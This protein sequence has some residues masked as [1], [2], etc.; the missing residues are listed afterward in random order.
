M[1]PLKKKS[2]LPFDLVSTVAFHMSCIVHSLP[3]F[4]KRRI[5]KKTTDKPVQE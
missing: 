1:L 5:H 4:L 3:G 2:F